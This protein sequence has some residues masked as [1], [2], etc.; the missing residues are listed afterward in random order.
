MGPAAAVYSAL[1]HCITKY[2]LLLTCDMPLIHAALLSDLIENA[3]ENSIN[4]CKAD[5]RDYPFPGLYPIT[6]TKSWKKLLD[7]GER[8]VLKICN[9]LNAV[10]VVFDHDMEAFM[11][12]NTRSDFDKLI[13][14]NK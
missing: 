9:Q 2:A 8:S 10:K 6:C 7:N 5:E 3:K 12:V 4:L 14:I 11:N 13:R 1:M